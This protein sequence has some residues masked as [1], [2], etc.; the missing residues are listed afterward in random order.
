MERQPHFCAQ[1][2]LWL[3]RRIN[4]RFETGIYFR[5]SLNDGYSTASA[6]AMARLAPN[7]TVYLL[8][9]RR[10]SAFGIVRNLFCAVS[11][12]ATS[13]GGDFT[14]VAERF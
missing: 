9:N 14:G 10:S 13:F 11:S 8:A 3:A 7:S 6:L 2:R 1:F 5:L 12:L 4:F